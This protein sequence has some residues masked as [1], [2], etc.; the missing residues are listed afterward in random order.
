[1]TEARREKRF[2]I[3]E[4]CNNSQCVTPKCPF[5]KTAKTP[6]SHPV[7]DLSESCA[8]YSPTGDGRYGRRYLFYTQDHLSI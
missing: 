6:E 1:M 8:Y 2:P 5:R 7:S 3:L 4:H